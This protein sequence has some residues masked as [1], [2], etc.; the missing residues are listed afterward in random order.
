MRINKPDFN[1]DYLFLKQKSFLIS[2]FSF[3]ASFL[4]LFCF[5]STVP[6]QND[7]DSINV[8]SSLVVLNATITDANG[9]ISFGLK[10]SQFK[11]FED[12]Q[13]QKLDFFEAAKTPF[14]AVVLLDTSGS[15]EPRIA[16]ARSAAINFLDGLRVDDVA[17]IYNFDTKVS[18][19]QNF[20][21]SRDITDQI[22]NIKADGNTALND[23]VV[24]AAAELSK[25]AEKRRAIVVLSDGAD[26]KSKY[27]GDKALKA[28]I[29]ANATIYTI[30]MSAID[31]GGKDRM[32]SQG[33]LKNFAEKSGGVFIATGGGAAMRE[34]FKNIV[35]E[36]GVQYTLGYQPSNLKKDGK[37][38]AI[39]IRVAKPNLI[40]RTRKG[41]YAAKESK[42]P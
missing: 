31:T 1:F 35:E 38:R 36:L 34:A 37:F 24:K 10:E 42:K 33:A 23:A 41:Y 5:I 3:L 26:N 27:S 25:R 29:A 12:G 40:I 30:D 14:A 7:D 21:N 8:E 19:V 6:A 11:V 39:E 15:M 2:H 22:F 9:K 18:L 17:A 32:Q 4:I 20:S 16:M 28:A 13:E